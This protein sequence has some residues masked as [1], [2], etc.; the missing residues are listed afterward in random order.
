[1]VV[2]G[3]ER[4]KKKKEEKGNGKSKLFSIHVFG[5]KKKR[6]KKRVKSNP[7]FLSLVCKLRGKEI[8][9]SFPLCPLCISDIF[10]SFGLAKLRVYL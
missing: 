2:V 1:M 10:L 5:Y 3:E 4:E 6:K 9:I 7:S 8:C